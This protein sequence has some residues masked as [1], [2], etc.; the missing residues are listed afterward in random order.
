MKP[1]DLYE[2]APESTTMDIFDL[3]NGHYYDHIPEIGVDDWWNIDF[4]KNSRIE[5]RTIKY[6][7][8]DGR[9]TWELRTVWFDNKPVMVIQNAGR[10]GD[11]Y[12]K[13]YVTDR[14]A[15]TKMVG[16]LLS[17][18]RTGNFSDTVHDMD[19][20]IPDLG[21]FWGYSLGGTFDFW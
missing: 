17:L 15:Y 2:M 19:E 3:N 14:D 4:S 13:R 21:T 9:R 12:A 1:R 6:H 8:F 16:Y 5:I 20:D 10:E 7:C 18:M 11:D